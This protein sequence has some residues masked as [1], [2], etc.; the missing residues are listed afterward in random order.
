MIPPSIPADEAE[1]VTELHNLRILDTPAEERF[2]RITRIATHLFDVPIALISLVDSNRQ[3]FKSCQGITDR[4]TPREVSF[5]GHAILED[6]I[7]FVPDSLKDPRFVDNPLVTAEGGI[8]FYAGSPL[9]G[10]GGHKIGTICIADRKPR[11][12]SEVEL[13]QLSDLSSWASLELTAAVLLQH[14]IKTKTEELQE[15]ELT[16]FRFMERLPVGVFVINNAGKPYYANETALQLLGKGIAKNVEPDQLADV[17]QVYMEG[18]GQ[19]YPIEKLPI[20]RALGGLATEAEDIEIHR[21]DGILSLQVWATP[22]IN[23]YGNITHAVAAFQDITPRKNAE[24]RL[25]AH[26]AV[27]SILSE[28]KNLE[29]ARPEILRAI[30]ENVGWDVGVFY[31]VE[32][33]ENVLRCVD[34]WNVPN[35]PIPEFESLTRKLLFPPGLGLPGRVLSDMEPMWIADIVE[36]RNFPRTPAALKNGLHAGFGFPIRFNGNVIAVMEFFSRYVQQ[37]DGQLLKLLNALGYQIGQFIG[38][39]GERD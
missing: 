8:R 18:T 35:L 16:F 25:A 17:Y 10:P 7:M 39:H 38:Q 28:A 32:A 22:I 30:C 23:K 9:F 19:E 12:F 20:L 4:E 13:K 24:R 1:R 21:P 34:I 31:D 27:T 29:E 26:A 6:R 11:D 36:D 5:C 2:D 3:W 33:Q 15:K 14:E 37:R